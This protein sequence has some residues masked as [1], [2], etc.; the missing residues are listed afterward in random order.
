MHNCR[1]IHGRYPSA[2]ECTWISHQ[3]PSEN[4]IYNAV[5]N[6][7]RIQQIQQQNEHIVNVKAGYGMSLCTLASLALFQSSDMT[8]MEDIIW[9]IKVCGLI[10]MEYQEAACVKILLKYY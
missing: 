6:S 3:T 8:C 4:Q 2:G 5:G 1:G 7:G 10:I 9:Q